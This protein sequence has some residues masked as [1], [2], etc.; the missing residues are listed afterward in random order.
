MQ[1]P[2]KDAVMAIL[3]WPGRLLS[4]LGIWLLAIV[5]LFEE[6]GWDQLE[7]LMAWMGRWP[8]IRQIEALVQRLPPYGALALFFAPMLSLLPVKLLA[9]YWIGQGHAAAGI[10]VII[11]AKLVGTAVLA[12]LFSLTHPTLMRLA[13][14]AR[15]YARWMAL[16]QRALGHVRATPAWRAWLATRQGIRDWW[17]AW[18]S[19]RWPD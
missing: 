7:R 8:G 6:W 16:K 9:L 12:R 4:W 15:L 10:A 1:S 17:R 11:A 18:R 2:L 14:F 19:R 3:R 13:W 5:L